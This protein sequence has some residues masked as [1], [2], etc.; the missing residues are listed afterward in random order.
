MK[1]SQ[2]WGGRAKGR[3]GDILSIAGGKAEP[4]EN[5]IPTTGGQSDDALIVRTL[6]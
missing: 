5:K 6:Q 4:K 2:G 1:F 3:I